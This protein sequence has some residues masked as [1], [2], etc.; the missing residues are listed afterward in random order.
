MKP[1]FET[2]FPFSCFSRRCDFFFFASSSCETRVGVPSEVHS[3]T[4]RAALDGLRDRPDGGHGHAHSHGSDA[5]GDVSGHGHSHGDADATPLVRAT[6][7]TEDGIVYFQA[8]DGRVLHSHDGLKPHS[9]D[10]IPNAGSFVHRR[11]RLTDRD[12]R[13]RAFT[14]GIG[15]PVGTGKTALMLS[16]CRALRDEYRVAA[17]R[18]DIFTRE[19]GEYLIKHQALSDPDSP[20]R[21]DRRLP[22]RRHPRG[23]LVQ[24]D[25]L[26]A[27]GIQRR[28]ILLDRAATTCLQLLAARR[29]HRVRH[30]RVR[31]G[32]DPAQGRAGRHAGGPAGDQQGGA[33]GR[34]RRRL[35]GDGAGGRGGRGGLSARVKRGDGVPDRR[36]RSRRVEGT[37]GGKPRRRRR[38]RRRFR[39]R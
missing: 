34:G 24:P 17:I 2:V 10:P 18:G 25:G 30:R 16:L 11:T 32:Q 15:G 35:G 27:H 29:L 6:G 36:A 21:G 22:A 7:A 39:A 20:R 14:I 9:H 37:T 1:D 3:P 38:N 23:H 31:R 8:P 4:R 19:D 33:G 5:P 26:I 28:F 12:Y 13:D